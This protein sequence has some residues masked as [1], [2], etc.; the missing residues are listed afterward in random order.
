MNEEV[1]LEGLSPGHDHLLRR[2]YARE[3]LTH[4]VLWLLRRQVFRYPLN[5]DS[6]ECKIIFLKWITVLVFPVP[7][8]HGLPPVEVHQCECPRSVQKEYQ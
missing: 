4:E 3:D 7:P 2:E 6:M 1:V 5:K 8:G